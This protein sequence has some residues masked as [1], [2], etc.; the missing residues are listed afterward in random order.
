MQSTARKLEQRVT[1]LERELRK[2]RSELK[3]VPKVSRQPWWKQVA[4]R[5]KNN[6]LF[7]QTMDAG[8]AYRRSP[9]AGARCWLS[10]DTDDLTVR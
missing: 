7:D 5:F 9:T 4:G 2:M 6:P 8:S 1:V 10:G 3:A